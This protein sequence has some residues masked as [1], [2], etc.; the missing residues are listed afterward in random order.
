MTYPPPQGPGTGKSGAALAVGVLATV[1][2]VVATVLIAVLVPSRGKVEGVALAAGADGSGEEGSA[3]TSGRAT[4]KRPTTRPSTS[5]TNGGGSGAPKACEYKV[6]TGGETKN[7]GVPTNPTEVPTSGTVLITLQT[8]EGNIPVRLDRS[9]APCAVHS[10]LFLIEKKFYD[11]T[12]CHRLTTSDS[13]KVLQCGDPT[14]SGRGGPGYEY[15]NEEPTELK[16]AGEGLVVYPTATVAMANAGPDTNGSQFFLVYGDSKIPPNYPVLGTVDAAGITTLTGIATT[17]TA[18][19]GQDGPPKKPVVVG[20][21]S[22][23]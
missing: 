19:G 21:V 12:P 20:A 10:M 11:A 4:P 17:G 6:A 5:A 3:S 2:I 13:L 7:V 18:D 22:T 8:T 15:A 9:K 1:L 16:S 23:N 14:G